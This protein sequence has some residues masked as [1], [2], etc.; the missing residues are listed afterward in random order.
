[1][2]SQSRVD[3]I[4]M[5]TMSTEVVNWVDKVSFLSNDELQ[6]E[7]F[8]SIMVEHGHKE[9]EILRLE[10]ARIDIR[11]DLEK[12]AIKSQRRAK[13][14]EDLKSPATSSVEELTHKLTIAEKDVKDARRNMRSWYREIRKFALEFAPELFLL[15]PDLRSPGS[16]LGDGGFAENA[17]LIRRRLDEYD[18][19]KPLTASTDSVDKVPTNARGSKRHILLTAKYDNE[20]VVLKGFVVQDAEQRKG[21]EKELSIL[22]RLKSDSIIS[23]VALVEDID[24]FD[25]SKLLVTVYI[26]YP[27]IKGG[28]LTQWLKAEQRKP[29]ELQSIARQLLYG[30]MYLHDHGVIHKDIKPSNILLHEDGRIVLSDFELSREI[31]AVYEE[32]ESSTVTSSGTKGFMS[33]EVE[34][35]EPASCAS[36]MYSFGVLLYYMHF[37][38]AFQT[39]IAGNPRIPANNDPEL[40]DLLQLLLALNPATRPRAAAALMHSY[41]RATFVE[42]LMQEGEVVEQD[43]KLEAVRNLLHKARSENRTNLDRINVNRDNVVPSVLAYF[44]EMPLEK[45]RA[46]LKVTFNGEPGVDEGGLLTEMFTL[47]FESIFKGHDSS[48]LFVGSEASSAH[49]AESLDDHLSLSAD[50]S[51]AYESDNRYSKVISEVVLPN[52]IDASP[53]RLLDLRAVGRAIVKALYEGRRIGSRL[54]PAVFKFLTDSVPNMRDLQMFDPQTAKSLQWTLATIGVEE[55]GLHFESVGAPELGHVTDIN[56]AQFVNMKIES[57]LVQSRLPHLLAM[58]AG[59]VEALKGISAEA[60]PFMSLLSHTDWRVMLCG[61]P[62]VNGAKV[63]SAFKFTGF[64]KKSSIPTWLKEIIMASSE[65]HLRKFLV[66]VTGSPSFSSS[67]SS[68]NG[69]EINVRCQPRS[70]AL[71]VAHTCFFH[72]DIPDYKDKDTLQ[73]KLL[74][75]IQNAT[76]FEVV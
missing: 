8:D 72:L 56:K 71:P 51:D 42:R 34:A 40:V 50:S 48:S 19:V 31:G 60:A 18:D 5:Q 61:D 38:T 54:S 73:T 9:D 64:T 24:F 55:F 22:G 13:V 69:L 26:E 25:K 47:F 44:R 53:E 11:S 58:K 63:A 16:V 12:A 68:R 36:D 7:R 6:Q 37:P 75:A 27:Y 30:L 4:E 33:P 39:L 14:G 74:Y 29:W 3:M 62:L 35:G 46:L 49:S 65:D 32:E 66:F 57:I 1:M 59:F 23:P 2:L 41:F 76:T 10:D 43:R 21:L 45:M 52:N 20:E 70:G 28:N 67:S 15:L 17:K